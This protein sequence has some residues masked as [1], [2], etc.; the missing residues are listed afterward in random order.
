MD[1]LVIDYETQSL[2]DIADGAA[3]YAQHE[4]T[5]VL[6]GVFLLARD[7]GEEL[8]SCWTPA[9]PLPAW[10]VRHVAAGGLTLAH[11]HS[12]ESCIN[13]YTLRGAFP[14]PAEHWRDTLQ[15]A[16]ALG[17]PLSLAGLG[18]A[19]GAKVA[20]DDEGHELMLRLSKIRRVK[21]KLVAPEVTPADLERL[22]AYCETDVRSTL[23]CWRRLPALPPDELR[24]MAVDHRINERGVA[25]DFTLAA[26]M[27]GLAAARR[28][29]IAGEVWR[30]TEDL[31][32]VSSP[33]ALIRYARE[34]GVAV[35]KVL[36]K[37]ANGEKR[38]SESLDRAAID[39]LLARTDL[40]DAVRGT[41]LLRVEAGRVTSLAKLARLEEVANADGRARW[42]LRYAKA[43]T[44]RWASEILQLHNLPRPTKAFS[45]W[46]SLALDAVERGDIDR[47]AAIHPVLEALSFLLRALVV[48]PRGRVLFG[49]DYAAI[50]ARI[51]AW[52]AGQE[53]VLQLFAAGTDVYVADAA[54]IGSD[55]RNLGKACRLGLGFQMGAVRFVDSAAKHGVEVTP[56]RAKEVVTSWRDANPRIVQLWS[57]LETAFAEAHRAR[58]GTFPVGPRLLV[59]GSPE[60]VRV[61]LPSGRSLYYWRPHERPARKKVKVVSAEGLVEEI[62]IET[63]EQR[64]FTRRGADMVVEGTY[65]GHL[66]ENVTQAVAR[67]LLRD[68]LIRLDATAYDVVLHVHDSIAA[69]RDAGT[70]SVPEFCAIMAGREPWGQ[71]LPVA[72]E[73][74]TSG[75]F[76][77]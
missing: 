55:N 34:H 43:T 56:A 3:A 25:L 27:R 10:A 70:G 23:E 35:P 12:F 57:D 17:L 44:G 61:E 32:D 31:T 60:N 36:R 69:E 53:D 74:Y 42:L 7:T 73:G 63:V 26:R 58:G 37:P 30:I 33:P 22:L 64:Y 4:T 28:E 14:M 6:C 49:G 46:S 19:I 48:A 59:H 21:G 68:A 65:G 75:R 62:E 16:A 71:S 5:R 77:G 15:I 9:A 76:K 11:N 45:Q 50:E 29:Q 39:E 66:T 13:R 40:P 24:M 1:I 47:L 20:K 52:L 38:M 8:V 72:V 2:A 41:L 51:V 67:D 18:A 54:A